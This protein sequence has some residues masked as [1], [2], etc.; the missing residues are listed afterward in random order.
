MDIPNY[1]ELY[2]NYKSLYEEQ[3]VENQKLRQSLLCLE[4][5]LKKLKANESRKK[6]YDL[7]YEEYKNMKDNGFKDEQIAANLKIS[8]RTLYRYLD[9]YKESKVRESSKDKFDYSVYLAK[10]R[11]GVPDYL[12]AK[13]FGISKSTLSR[14]LK[15]M[16]Q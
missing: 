9:N 5:E 2:M 12:I 15:K 13:E 16:K 3:K 11:A 6:K 14:L 7:T 1:Y 4:V 10:K 8:V